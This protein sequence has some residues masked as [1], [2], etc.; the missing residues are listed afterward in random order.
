MPK[1]GINMKNIQIV[2]MPKEVLEKAKIVGNIFDEIKKLKR[3]LE[4][5]QKICMIND[6]DCSNK[7]LTDI[8]KIAHAF[9]GTCGNPHNDWKEFEKE[10]AEKLKNY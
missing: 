5:I 3:A 9:E 10:M 6:E 8:Y 2:K 4:T 7:I 1:L